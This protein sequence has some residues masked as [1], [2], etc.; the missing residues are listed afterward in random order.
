VLPVCV[1]GKIV[2]GPIGDRFGAPVIMTALFVGV[3]ASV[4]V[5]GLS[6]A[7][8]PLLAVS[9][10]AVGICSVGNQ[11][12]INV[13]SANVYPTAIRSAGVCVGRWASTGLARL[14]APSWVA[15]C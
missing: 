15:C 9:I 5:I 13:M 14:S 7:S 11:S 10:T 3:A 8:I 1:V 12:F 6:G 4:F 2:H